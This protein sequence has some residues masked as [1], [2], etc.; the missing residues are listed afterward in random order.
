MAE[1][2]VPAGTVV[3]ALATVLAAIGAWVEIR[4][5][6]LAEEPV[7]EC[8]LSSPAEN[9]VVLDLAVRNR[10]DASIVV[11]GL[12]V[13]RPRRARIAAA[14]RR[15]ADT[16]SGLPEPTARAVDLSFLVAPQGRGGE[17]ALPGLPVFGPGEEAR[18]VA[19]LH[20]PPPPRWLPSW[21]SRRRRAFS[22]AVRVT[23]TDRTARTRSLV[24][25]RIAPQ[26]KAKQIAD[27][28]HS[29]G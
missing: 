11:S 7:V 8:F 9:V 19:A 15:F 12:A 20:L 28:P 26:A 16:P 23:S 24:I 21:L 27:R 22:I 13:R 29:Q 10:S 25:E 4:M 14:L 17:Q 1:W 2:I 3:I 5:R 18:F 6:R